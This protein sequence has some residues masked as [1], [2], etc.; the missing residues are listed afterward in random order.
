MRG[1]PL[2]AR[3]Y[4][5]SPLSGTRQKGCRAAWNGGSGAEEKQKEA[6]G[7]DLITYGGG[8][9]VWEGGGKG[10]E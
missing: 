1:V 9:G 6:R 5:S 10:A 4:I 8:G 3:C 7:G 2:G